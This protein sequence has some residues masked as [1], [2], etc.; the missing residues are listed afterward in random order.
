MQ[1]RPSASELVEAVAQFINQEIIPQAQDQRN[2]FRS[3][4][5]ANVLNI[6]ARELAAGEEP[7]LAEWHSLGTLLD[8][9]SS[10]APERAADLQADVVARN[11]QLCARIRSGDFDGAAARTLLDEHLLAVVTDKLRIANPPYLQRVLG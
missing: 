10:Q 11:E 5:A 8:D 2:R 4:V 3:L 9:I 1:D 6:V 7:L